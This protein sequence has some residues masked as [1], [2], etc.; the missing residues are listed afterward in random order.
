MKEGRDRACKCGTRSHRCPKS[1][2]A[3]RKQSSRKNSALAEYASTR[4]LVST[5]A[6]AA[7]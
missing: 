4:M 7:M 6:T 5:M 2:K 3:S 1:M